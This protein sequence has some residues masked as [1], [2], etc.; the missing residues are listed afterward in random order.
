MAVPRDLWVSPAVS[1]RE[2]MQRM[3]DA[4]AGFVLV[5]TE[6]DGLFGV[7]TDGDIRRAIIAGKSLDS[8]VA[9]IATRQP[10]TAPPE[11]TPEDLIQLMQATQ[12]QMVPIVSSDGQV[13]RIESL[14]DLIQPDV[15]QNHAVI[16]AGGY[17]SRL[18]PYTERVPKP[19]LQVDAKPMVEHMVERLVQQGIN[20][21]IMLLHHMPEAITEHFAG[22]RYR[23]TELEFVIEEQPMGTAGGLR[24]LGDRLTMPFLVLNGDTLIR[25]NCAIC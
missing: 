13:F 24:L 5:V 22:R 2:A 17:G 15:L 20:R 23:G 19:M 16:M 11:A 9:E 6:N 25:A 3:T 8:E 21:I 1:I 10:V 7:V 18:R 12:K 14:S 4:K